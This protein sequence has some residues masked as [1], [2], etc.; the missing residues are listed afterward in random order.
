MDSEELNILREKEQYL[1]QWKSHLRKAE[2]AVPDAQANIEMTKWQI[3][4]L[5]NLPK[6]SG[7]TLPSNIL[8]I[9]K[10]D[11]DFTKKAFPLIPDYDIAVAGTATANTTG[12]AAT[13][14]NYVASYADIGS[15]QATRFSNK[16]TDQ[17]HKIQANQQRPDK[18]RQ[19]MEA[20]CSTNTIQRFNTA[21]MAYIR[22]KSEVGSR[23]EAANELRNTLYGL[24]GD[25]VELAGTAKDNHPWQKMAAALSKGGVGSNECQEVIRQ[26]SVRKTLD[27]RLANILKDRAEGSYTNLEDVWTEV[28]DHIYT[29]LSMLEVTSSRTNT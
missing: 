1:D 23:R 12:A 3:D 27:S 25:L 14:Y 21:E 6:P 7:S 17:Y 20:F 10:R 16:Y 29:V 18:V 28:L 15:P 26:N 2:D 4:A 22:A 9:L 11:Y 19:L 24:N 5:T 8:D 13:I